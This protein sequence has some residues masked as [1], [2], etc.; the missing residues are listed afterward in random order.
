MFF[1]KSNYP[2]ILARLTICRMFNRKSCG[3][4]TP[5]SGS[6]LKINRSNPR[7]DATRTSISIS[8]IRLFFDFF[9]ETICCDG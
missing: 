1:K 8:S 9:S 4:I 5:T 6:Q 2:Q 7:P 3:A